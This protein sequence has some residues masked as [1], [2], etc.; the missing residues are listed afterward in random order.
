MEGFIGKSKA[1]QT[2]QLWLAVPRIVLGVI[3]VVTWYEN[4]AKGLYQADNFRGFI[5]YLAE[6]HTIGPYHAFLTGVVAP[7][8]G[9]F[10]TFQLVT[11]LL[12]GLAL[13]FGALTPLAGLGALF[14]FANLFVAYLNPTLGEWIW[15]HVMLLTMAAMSTFGKSGRALG[16]DLLLLQHWGEPKYPFY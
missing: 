2:S 7:N 14:F 15:T 12:M 9:L 1:A 6:G 13:I 10:A 4:L 11:E 3:L 16:I 8:A 5:L